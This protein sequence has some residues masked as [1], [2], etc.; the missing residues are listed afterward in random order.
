MTLALALFI[1]GGGA[2]VE[3]LFARIAIHTGARS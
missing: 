2:E 1:A 3:T